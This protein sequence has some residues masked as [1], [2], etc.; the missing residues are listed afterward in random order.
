[1]PMTEIARKLDSGSRLSSNASISVIAMLSNFWG[2][3]DVDVNVLGSARGTQL[4]SSHD[5]KCAYPYR[6]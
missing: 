6:P 5:L 1:M 3:I 2:S 4:R